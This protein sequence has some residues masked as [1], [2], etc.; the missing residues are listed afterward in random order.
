MDPTLSYVSN[1]IYFGFVTLTTLGYGDV[2]PL[3]PAAKSLAIFTSITGQMYV[4]IIIAAL[5]SK[6]LSQP[7]KNN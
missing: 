3:T 6:Y 7:K 5:V 4:A 2:V 1:Y